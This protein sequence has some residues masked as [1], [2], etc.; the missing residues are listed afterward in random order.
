MLRASRELVKLTR[1]WKLEIVDEHH[2]I[3][4]E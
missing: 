2:K 3:Q 4:V 1:Y